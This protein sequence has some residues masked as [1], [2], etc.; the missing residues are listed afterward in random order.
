MLALGKQHSKK[1]NVLVVGLGNRHIA[2]DSLGAKVVSEV[3]LNS[4]FI[5]AY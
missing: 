1:D 5:T 3:P 2:Y 4:P